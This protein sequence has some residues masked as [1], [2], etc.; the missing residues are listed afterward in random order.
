MKVRYCVNN[1][2]INHISCL[3]SEI[4]EAL[5]KLKENYSCSET[6][7][8]D[9]TDINKTLYIY[10]LGYSGR[11]VITIDE[12]RTIYDIENMIYGKRNK[13]KYVFDIFNIKRSLEC[14]EKLINVTSHKY[15]CQ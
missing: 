1:I 2:D 13:R 5:I 9:I 4:K 11:R 14:I 15:I 6:V 10:Y 7:T 12:C 3:L 8:I